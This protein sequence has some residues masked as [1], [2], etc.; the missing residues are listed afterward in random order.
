MCESVPIESNQ[1]MSND[2]E[3]RAEKWAKQL[4]LHAKE[5]PPSEALS[6][7]AL[8]AYGGFALSMLGLGFGLGWKHQVRR[9]C[10]GGA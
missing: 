6:K 4:E 8:V 7:P 9:R 5:A 10:K 2:G 1:R 3:S